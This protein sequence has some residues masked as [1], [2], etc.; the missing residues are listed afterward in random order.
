MEIKF[1]GCKH[2]DFAPNYTA[3]R[4]MMGNGCLF[5]MRKVEP[6][7]PA[8]VQFCK[9]RGRLNYPEACVCSQKNAQCNDYEEYLH[10]IN[11]TKEELE[12]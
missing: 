8:M 5:W 6:S 9:L 11:V 4:Q 1:T 2:L 12:S 7:L 3:K 10:V